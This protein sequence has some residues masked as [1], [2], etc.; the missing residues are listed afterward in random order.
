MESK[1]IGKLKRHPSVEGWHESEA[2]AVPL[3][4]NQKVSFIIE[5][6]DGDNKPEDFEEAV[7]CFMKLSAS[8]KSEIE[9]YIFQ[10]Y[11][12]IRKAVGV[13]HCSCDLSGPEDVWQFID[14]EYVSLSRRLYG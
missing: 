9:P 10:H 3:L 5:D 13:E 2:V 7:S 4:G 8:L 14:P 11:S 12:D 1:A 6:I